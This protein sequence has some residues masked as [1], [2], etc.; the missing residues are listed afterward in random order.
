[1]GQI[2]EEKQ[3]N[4]DVIDSLLA[5]WMSSVAATHHFLS[6]EEIETIRPDVKAAL[7]EIDD[8]FCY[9]TEDG[10]KGF[11]GV[12]EGKIEMLFVADDSRGQGIGKQLVLFVRKHCGAC[13]VDVNE[14]NTQGVGFYRHLGFTQ[15][16]RSPLDGQGRSH[17]ILH[18]KIADGS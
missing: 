7:A 9:Q 12:A 5:V 4:E 10:Y 17:P 11:V 8:L 13:Y 14:Q 3:R 1:M 2:V 16:G 6:P 15:I 18:F